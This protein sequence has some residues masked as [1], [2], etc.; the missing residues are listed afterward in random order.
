MVEDLDLVFQALAHPARRKILDVLRR[1]PGLCAR[2]LGKHFDISRIGVIKHLRVLE[3]AHL[4]TLK[5]NGRLKELYFNLVPIQ[6]IYDRW[7]TDYSA[8]WSSKLVD[9]KTRL[10]A[11]VKA[12]PPDPSPSRS[13]AA[14]ARSKSSGRRPLTLPLEKST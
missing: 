12:T 13:R 11:D 7:T 6:M 10:E 8:F 4:I 14:A 5:R 3:R 9:L 2:D 1:K